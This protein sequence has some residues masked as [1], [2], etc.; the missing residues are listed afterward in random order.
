[1]SP[2]ILA[3]VV[4][5]IGFIFL[6][7]LYTVLTSYTC[8]YYWDDTIMPFFLSMWGVWKFLTWLVLNHDP[9]AMIIWMLTDFHEV[10][11]IGVRN[12][13]QLPYR[14]SSFVLFSIS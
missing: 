8:Y 1:M 7:S 2:A 14:Y 10:R 13:T 4:L 11:A 6:P 5:D 9:L 12:A 3:L